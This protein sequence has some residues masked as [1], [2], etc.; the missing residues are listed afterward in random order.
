MS[1]WLALLFHDGCGFPKFTIAIMVP[2]NLFMLAMFSDFYYKTYILKARKAKLAAAAAAAA[3][4][5]DI[6]DNTEEMY[7]TK[8]TING[9]SRNRLNK[10]YVNGQSNGNLSH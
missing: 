3:A 8:I 2:Q 1:H 6:N 10:I 4:K 7:P 5:K 9:D